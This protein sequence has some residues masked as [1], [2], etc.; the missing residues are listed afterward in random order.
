MK[1][2]R[3]NVTETLMWSAIDVRSCQTTAQTSVIWVDTGELPTHNR[4][5]LPLPPLGGLSEISSLLLV[6]TR[7]RRSRE[8]DRST[9]SEG[10]SASSTKM[11]MGTERLR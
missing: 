3:N 4:M 5:L 10:E 6:D 2:D 1:S 7:H 9:D 11:E 8:A